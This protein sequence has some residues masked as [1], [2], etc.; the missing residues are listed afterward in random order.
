MLP[1]G[2]TVFWG[3]G[4]SQAAAADSS[5][6]RGDAAADVNGGLDAAPDF[7]VPAEEEKARTARYMLYME[8]RGLNANEAIEFLLQDANQSLPGRLS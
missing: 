8:E 1:K 2:G 4:G 3:G 5:S 6:S 7:L